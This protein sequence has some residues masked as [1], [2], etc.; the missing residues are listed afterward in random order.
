[1]AVSTMKKLSVIIM[2]EDRDK[3]L[4]ALQKLR[5]VDICQTEVPPDSADLINPAYIYSSEVE[6]TARLDVAQKSALLAKRTADARAAA[7][8]LA[9]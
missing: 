4:R 7:D 1:M 8:F 6:G 5:C 2:R 3:F 9:A